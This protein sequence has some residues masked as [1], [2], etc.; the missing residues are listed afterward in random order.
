MINTRKSKELHKK[1]TKIRVY[2]RIYVTNI[3]KVKIT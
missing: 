3:Y 1:E 2:Y